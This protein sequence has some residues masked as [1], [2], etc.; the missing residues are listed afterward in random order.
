M[1]D[2]TI[3]RMLRKLHAG[4]RAVG[5]QKALDAARLPG[6]CQWFLDDQRT[7]DWLAGNGPQL[8]W[9]HGPRTTGKTFLSSRLVNHIQSDDRLRANNAAVAV[10]YAE[11]SYQ[12]LNIADWNLRLWSVVRQLASQ[13]PTS[14]AG[15]HKALNKSS[16]TDEDELHTMLRI[17]A[18]EF[19]TVFIVFDGIDKAT[20]KGLKALMRVLV[21]N[22]TEKASFRVLITSR[23]PAPDELI[24][25]FNVSAVEARA[26]H[27]DLKAY[28]ASELRDALQGLSPLETETLLGAEFHRA[29]NGV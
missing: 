7:K 28:A 18:S 15:L 12:Y 9:L 2:A 22:D 26:S 21:E 24:E 6:S 3:A 29:C 11:Q 14:S 1:D 27:V 13:L 10:V 4:D 17:L 25:N 23:N 8:L 5:R 20:A 19:E 16:E